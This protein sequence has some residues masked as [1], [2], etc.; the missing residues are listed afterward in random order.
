MSTYK[1][2]YCIIEYKN[3]LNLV[4]HTV[5][6]HPKKELKHLEK[7]INGKYV[8]AN[9]GITCQE[10]L[11]RLEQGQTL[12]LDSLG[13]LVFK[14]SQQASPPTKD[15]TH[16]K[17]ESDKFMAGVFRHLQEYDRAYD[18]LSILR[19]ISDGS[20]PC[21]NLSLHLLLDIGKFLSNACIKNMRYS[22]DKDHTPTSEYCSSNRN[23]YAPVG[24]L[25]KVL[26]HKQATSR[27][28]EPIWAS[29]RC[30]VYIHPYIYDILLGYFRWIRP[31][32]VQKIRFLPEYDVI[33]S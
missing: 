9:F 25:I 33:T 10:V 8:C 30:D 4:N 16:F 15:F 14:K 6:D 32:K 19:H 12:A 28:Q 3:L 31:K 26:A 5:H 21:S 1:C 2:I 22:N 11:E 23:L 18:F 27:L 13:R 29:M 20:L 24:V 17:A 7:D